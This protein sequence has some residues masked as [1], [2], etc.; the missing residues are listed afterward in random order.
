MFCLLRAITYKLMVSNLLTAKN[1]GHDH[2]SNPPNLVTNDAIKSEVLTYE[3][4][5]SGIDSDTR[6]P[7]VLLHPLLDIFPH[8]QG[9]CLSIYL[10]SRYHL[11]SWRRKM[12]TK[13]MENT[14]RD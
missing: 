2:T 8:Q 10:A 4:M 5:E 14:P 12:L 3:E 11:L 6:S 13:E 9:C 1:P 7:I